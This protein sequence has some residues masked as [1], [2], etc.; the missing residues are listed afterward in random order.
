MV[1]GDKT[2]WTFDSSMSNSETEWHNRRRERS[3]RHSPDRS[4]D[5]HDSISSD[6]TREVRPIVVLL[7]VDVACCCVVLVVVVVVVVSFCR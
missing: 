5:I 1:T 4:V 3:E 6:E 2:G 7:L